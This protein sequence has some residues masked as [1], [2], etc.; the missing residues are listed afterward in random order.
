MKLPGGL[1]QSNKAQVLPIYSS[2]SIIVVLL[3]SMWQTVV[4]APKATNDQ[5]MFSIYDYISTINNHTDNKF[6]KLPPQD[7]GR[8]CLSESQE[9]F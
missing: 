9:S 1:A 8:L 6:L 3:A 2:N 7:N 5:N 4:G